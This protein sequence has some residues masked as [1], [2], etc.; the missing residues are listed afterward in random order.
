MIKKC[1]A[2]FTALCSLSICSYSYAGYQMEV[3]RIT[4]GDTIVVKA[5]WLLPELG[6]TI[7]IRAVGIDTPEKGH[8]AQC[9]H[10][11]A[12]SEHAT[13]LVRKLIPK[14]E[15][16]YVEVHGRDKYFR[17]LGTIR[18]RAGDLGEILIRSN[19]ARS[20]SGGTKQSWCN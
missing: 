15:I 4:D 3:V 2:I 12:L 6:N 20:Y 18:T 5:P 14:G 11:A 7:S 16:V 8:L 9:E 17:I 13:S 19:F 1:L 10:E